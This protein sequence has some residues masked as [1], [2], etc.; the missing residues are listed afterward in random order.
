MLAFYP[1]NLGKL[2]KRGLFK[3]STGK[4]LNADSID[5]PAYLRKQILIYLQTE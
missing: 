4:I 5:Q 3:N 2:L 1:K